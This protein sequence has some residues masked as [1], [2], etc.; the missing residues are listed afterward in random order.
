LHR[1]PCAGILG[2]AA[3]FFEAVAAVWA[4][5]DIDA[6]VA[7]EIFDAVDNEPTLVDAFT[8][9]CL[10]FLCAPDVARLQHCHEVA[11]LEQDRFGLKSLCLIRGAS[12]EA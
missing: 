12:A 3:K 1:G 2:V 8:H 5:E 6:A 4:P 7:L 10:F 9:K 11:V